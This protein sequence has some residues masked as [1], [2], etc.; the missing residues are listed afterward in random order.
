MAQ[1]KDRSPDIP[2][3][4]PDLWESELFRRRRSNELLNKTPRDTFCCDD[5]DYFDNYS[6]YSDYDRNSD[7]TTYGSAFNPDF[8]SQIFG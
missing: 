4:Q 8:K 3:L 2:K 5:F 7:I 1:P 6:S